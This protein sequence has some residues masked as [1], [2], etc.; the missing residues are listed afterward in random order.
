V[1]RGARHIAV[2]TAVTAA[3]DVVGAARQLRTVIKQ[4]NVQ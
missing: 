3:D 1:A 4:E 2:V